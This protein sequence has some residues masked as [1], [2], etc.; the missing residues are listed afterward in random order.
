[1]ASQYLKKFKELILKEPKHALP[2]MHCENCD[3]NSFLYKSKDC[4]LCFASSRLQDCFH[5]NICIESKDCCDTTFCQ[6]CELCYECLDCENSYEC[7]F[8]QD[9]NN[10]TDCWFC[11]DCVGCTDC[12]GCVGLRRQTHHF[13]NEKCTKEE[14]KEKTAHYKKNFHDPTIWKEIQEQFEALQL[15]EPRL[16]MR[17]HSNEHIFG[18]YVTNAKNG[19]MIF[20]ANEVEDSGYVYDEVYHVRDC[21][22]VTHTHNSE[23]CSDTGSCDYSYGCHDCFIIVSCRD[24]YHCNFCEQ[25]EHCFM[26]ANLKHKKFHI[27]NEPYSEE[28][29]HAKVAEIKEELKQEELY[30]ENLLYL[31]TKDY[32][33]TRQSPLF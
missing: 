21:F 20:G 26:C 30:G 2:M 4:Y 22:D 16:Y 8:S 24:C 15:K 17:G 9:L 13:F 5:A 19:Y 11:F 14:Y 1:M 28:D 32:M 31:A 18:D 10:C 33:G 29:Y 25:C 12:F 27:L 7:T 3:Y 6:E 23:L